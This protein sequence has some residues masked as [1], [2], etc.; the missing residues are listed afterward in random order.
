MEFSELM[1]AFAERVKLE[2]IDFDADEVA[3]VVDG[4]PVTFVNE[5]EKRRILVVGQIGGALA[6][7]DDAFARMLLRSNHLFG[8]TAGATLSQD[9]QTGDYHLCQ[10][11]D[12]AALDLIGFLAAAGTFVNM[13]ESWRAAREDFT[14]AAEAASAVQ[15]KEMFDW[16]MFTNRDFMRA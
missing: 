8:G 14:P 9:A 5:R 11:I 1:Q 10:R 16:A 6:E 12:I 2:G 3:F 13:L 4:M 15:D 7:G